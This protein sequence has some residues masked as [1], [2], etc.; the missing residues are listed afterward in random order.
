MNQNYS[1][2][3]TV[4]RAQGLLDK[5]TQAASNSVKASQR[6]K[7]AL[8]RAKTHFAERPIEAIESLLASW[9]L[10]DSSEVA[11]AGRCVGELGELVRMLRA[12]RVAGF[13]AELARACD[14]AGRTLRPAT[15]GFILGSVIVAIDAQ[16]LSARV[17]YAKLDVAKDLALS[18]PAVL[19]CAAEVEAA[20]FDGIPP[21]KDLAASF[22]EA[23]KVA[24]VR[25]EGRLPEG[26]IR[27][28]LPRVYAEM[29]MIRDGGR[30][31][32]QLKPA[33]AYSLARFVAELVTLIRS[34]VNEKLQRFR[35]ETAVLEN[36]GN[37]RKSVF[38]PHDLM[39]GYGEGCYYQALVLMSSR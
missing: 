3:K 33:S 23:V 38:V 28:E 9:R 19:K 20:I 6:M 8:S 17:A 21:A 11:E 14:Q 4:V 30:S 26:S 2:D 15:D 16:K 10:P 24:T 25:R 13:Q 35:L 5:A 34:D 12:E 1:E 32:R 39:A 22:E 18:A 27:A 37:A 29:A 7:A 36:A 31:G